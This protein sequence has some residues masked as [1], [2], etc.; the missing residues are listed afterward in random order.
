MIVRSLAVLACLAP[1]LPASAYCIYNELP[2]RDV[3]IA[4]DSDRGGGGM[5]LTLKPKDKF[6]CTPKDTECNPEGKVTSNVD[7]AITVLG[8]PK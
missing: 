1:A 2:N 6:C 5:N 3:H 4:R 8:T 7:I